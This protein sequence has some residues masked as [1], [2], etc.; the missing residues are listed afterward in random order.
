M[1]RQLYEFSYGL[2]H[3]SELVARTMTALTWAD[4]PS[5]GGSRATRDA[6]ESAHYIKGERMTFDATRSLRRASK[7]LDSAIETAL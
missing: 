6:L 1:P 3:T 5:E 7:I 2:D 4:L